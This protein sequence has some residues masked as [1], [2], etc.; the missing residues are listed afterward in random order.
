MKQQLKK[1]CLSVS[2]A[3]IMLA[4]AWIGLVQ[5]SETEKAVALDASSKVEYPFATGKDA[6]KYAPTVTGPT[7]QSAAD[8][9][10]FLEVIFDP[11]VSVGVDFS[12]ADYIAIQM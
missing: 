5:W 7:E 8:S 4:A 11:D 9:W 12:A 2:L 1:A 3:V 6:F 10:V